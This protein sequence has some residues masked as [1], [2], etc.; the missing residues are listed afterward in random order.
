MCNFYGY[1]LDVIATYQSKITR[2]EPI[3]GKILA[4]EAEE[5]ELRA[6]QSQLSK[7]EELVTCMKS[8]TAPLSCVERRVDWFAE[9]KRDKKT[10]GR[11]KLKAHNLS[12]CLILTFTL[13]NTEFTF[14]ERIHF[15]TCSFGVNIDLFN[16]SSRHH[17]MLA[18]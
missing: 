6:A 17:L 7:A 8:E 3:I 16:Q 18:R 10:I 15:Q 12:M 14:F 11:S 5:R 9:R 13:I 1:F 2:L 4:A